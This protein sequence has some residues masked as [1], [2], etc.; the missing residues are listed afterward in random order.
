MRKIIEK[1]ICL[2]ITAV[3]L[4]SVLPF[5]AIANDDSAVV[6]VTTSSSTVS[7]P[8]GPTENIT[9]FN[10]ATAQCLNYD[11]GT[12][13]NGTTVRTWAY[14][15]EGQNWDIIR[16]SDGVFRIVANANQSYALDVYC[17]GRELKSGLSLDIW[18]SGGAEA[19]AQNLV[20]EYSGEGNYYYLKMAKNKK[21][22]ISS[23]GK[24]NA[25]KLVKFTG[26][27][28][29]K[30]Y[31]KDSK[32]KNAVDVT[33]TSGNVSA[34]PIPTNMYVKSSEA[35]TVDGC[36][37][38]RATTTEACTS[39]L[40]ETPFWIDGSGRVVLNNEINNKLLRMYD[41]NKRQSEEMFY[42]D[43]LDKKMQIY[44]ELYLGMNNLNNFA[45]FV[46]TSSGALLSLTANP[47]IGIKN[48]SVKLV[49]DS[50]DVELVEKA[51]LVTMIQYYS[52]FGEDSAR[53]AIGIVEDNVYDYDSYEQVRIYIAQTHASYSAIDALIGKEV[54][55]YLN[56]T[57]KLDYALST[58][59][60]ILGSLADTVWPEG[61]FISKIV[62]KVGE[63]GQGI[64][65]LYNIVQNAQVGKIYDKI[66]QSYMS[67][68]LDYNFGFTAKKIAEMCESENESYN[69]YVDSG[70]VEK[71]EALKAKYPEGTK[72]SHNYVF[73]KTSAYECHGFACYAL[74]QFFGTGKPGISNKS[75]I[76]YKATSSNSYVE[77]IRPGDLVR[78]RSGNYDHTIVVTNVDESNI[79]YADCNSDL[80]CTFK[81]D[82]VMA[83]SKLSEMLKKKLNTQKVSVRGYILHYKNN[84]M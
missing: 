37:Y 18:K 17:P 44:S 58:L 29:Q 31:F 64:F 11:Y 12:L 83:K 65:S 68:E 60:N 4:I 40:A 79:Y 57:T 22:C 75:Y 50:I 7:S 36:K 9:V 19:F 52:T 27:D 53:L 46:G 14:D 16:V 81:Y 84:D 6:A 1:I 2:S 55:Q 39:V 45:F 59:R 3:M 54:E 20:I 28:A 62:E 63:S 71:L 24:N 49:K 25:L 67:V 70:L 26:E 74:M 32:G 23:N 41:F 61:T 78:F 66:Y 8:V 42:L 73:P 56:D 33:A 13:A 72:V 43:Y 38:Y 51:L 69:V 21:L 15:G 30:W 48:I 35:Y 5:S 10:K 80:K 77:K 47:Q 34:N 76:S 82:K